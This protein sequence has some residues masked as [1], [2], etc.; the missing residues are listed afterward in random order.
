MELRVERME[1]VVAPNAVVK[2]VCD[3]VRGF[4]VGLS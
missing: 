1:S 3:F 2:A 4:I